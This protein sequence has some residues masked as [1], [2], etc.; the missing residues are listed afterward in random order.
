MVSAV[1]KVFF[2]LLNKKYDELL[3]PLQHC[4]KSSKKSINIQIPAAISNHTSYVKNFLLIHNFLDWIDIDWE[5]FILIKSIS[6]LSTALLV[7]WWVNISFLS[8]T[9]LL[10]CWGAQVWALGAAQSVTIPR[11]LA[12]KFEVYAHKVYFKKATNFF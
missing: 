9:Y 5:M 11:N 6:C 12:T 2:P 1:L 8:K 3:M 4:Q 10:S 7:V